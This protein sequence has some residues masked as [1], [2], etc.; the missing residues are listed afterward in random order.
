MNPLPVP[1]SPFD[2][3]A[4]RATQGERPGNR[5]TMTPFVLSALRSKVYRSMTGASAD[6]LSMDK[7]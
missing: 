3:P 4:M 2:T 1:G 7:Q 5:M 6:G